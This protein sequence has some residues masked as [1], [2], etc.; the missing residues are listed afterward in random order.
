MPLNTPGV[1]RIGNI[2]R[3]EGYSLTDLMQGSITL[4]VIHKTPFVADEIANEVFY[5]L[6]S[7]REELKKFGIYKVTGFGI[8]KENVV[9]IGADKI[10]VTLVPINISFITQESVQKKQKQFKVKVY[11]E[12]QDLVYKEGIDYYIS[13]D[14]LGVHMIKETDANIFVDYVD[15][16]T[17]ENISSVNLIKSIEED[18]LYTIENSG[19][20]YGYYKIFEKFLGTIDNEE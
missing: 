3:S 12:A 18:T 6:S 16:I 7:V 9:T 19:K 14:G 15:A 8:G 11:S 13:P 17:L 10:H 20:I 5:Y 1:P 4:N 2:D